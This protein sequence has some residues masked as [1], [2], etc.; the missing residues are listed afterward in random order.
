MSDAGF[1][2]AEFL[3]STAILLLASAS[4]YS[5]LA[6][7]QRWTSYQSEVEAVIDNTRMA[8]ETAERILRQAGNNPHNIALSGI[9]IISS[10]QV[11][12]KS[13]L[14]GSL[15]PGQPDKGDPDGDVNDSWEDVTIRYNPASGTLDLVSAGGSAQAIAS[16]IT[17]FSLKY[18]DASGAET[19]IGN[20]VRE[21]TIT[22]S[23]AAAVPNPQTHIPFGI[24]LSSTVQIATR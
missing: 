21:I 6:E 4:V 12:I 10:T 23:G 11:R 8:I 22:I 16:Y 24:Q 14:T 3:L 15:G 19:S 18:Y 17:G 13:D 7:I 9:S 20:D 1:I 5:V 2:L